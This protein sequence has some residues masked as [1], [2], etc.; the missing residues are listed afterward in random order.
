M[1]TTLESAAAPD[2]TVMPPYPVK[3]WT[4]AEYRHLA[5]IGVLTEDDNVELLEGW[6][7]PKM[8]KNP[9]HEWTVTR[10][11]RL[12]NGLLTVDWITRTQCAI[13]TVDSEPEPDV[14]IVRG[15]EDRYLKH[16]PSG[17]EIG[18]VIEVADTSL[19]KDRRKTTM[20]AA[21]GI[22]VYWIVNLVD[23]QIEAHS[24]PELSRGVYQKRD[25]FRQ[26]E[27]IP[28]VLDG[29]AAAHIRVD[30]ILPPES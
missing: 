30:E 28:I 2:S 26:G 4:V 6:I 15:P 18:L 16:H 21:E 25:I 29:P 10:I 9:P 19:T 12:L 1:S 7:V 20:Y 27:S 24:S 13:N 22:P 11:G 3:R 23:D 14:S 8:T 5:E 17:E